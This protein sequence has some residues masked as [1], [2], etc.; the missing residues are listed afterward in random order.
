M[1]DLIQYEFQEG[2]AVI[3]MDDGKLNV[4]STKMLRELGEALDRAERDRAIVVLR[5]GRR[6]VFSAG[7]DLKML[8][9]NDS[10]RS[11]EMVKAGAEL[12]LD[13]TP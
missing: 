5:S 4:M 10:E 7:F 12:A 11:L 6:G 2:V 8:A 1:S 3:T 13:Q 9:A